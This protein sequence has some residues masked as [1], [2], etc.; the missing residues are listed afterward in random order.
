MRGQNPTGYESLPSG[1]STRRPGC[2]RRE[3]RATYAVMWCERRLFEGRRPRWPMRRLGGHF[4]YVTRGPARYASVV[5]GRRQ[6]A[7]RWTKNESAWAWL[8]RDVAPNAAVNVM[9]SRLVASLRN[10]T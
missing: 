3:P 9:T 6:R 7:V 8:S 4:G 10:L 2:E 5:K 1:M